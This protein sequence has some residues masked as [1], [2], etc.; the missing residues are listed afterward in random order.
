M[1]SKKKQGTAGAYPAR[2]ERKMNVRQMNVRQA[3]AIWYTERE[4]RIQA[5][6]DAGLWEKYQES[7]YSYLGNFLKSIGRY[8]LL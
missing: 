2:K 1:Q 4:K 5:V 6:K 7:R 3:R 8:D